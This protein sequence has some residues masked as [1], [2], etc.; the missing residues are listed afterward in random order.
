MRGVAVL[1]LG[2]AGSVRKA[3]SLFMLCCWLTGDSFIHIFVVCCSLLSAESPPGQDTNIQ[4][5]EL[6]RLPPQQAQWPVQRGSGVHSKIMP[7]TSL[8]VCVSLKVTMQRRRFSLFSN[9]FSLRLLGRPF[10]RIWRRQEP[11][12]WL[13]AR[14]IEPLIISS[15]NSARVPSRQ[16]AAASFV[17]W[18]F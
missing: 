10:P 16:L 15:Q 17:K 3:P 11:S 9:A 1:E 13:L 7:S 12:H 2:L 14:F 6:Q 8:L 5:G 4:D 18:H